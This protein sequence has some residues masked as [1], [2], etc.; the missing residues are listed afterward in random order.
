MLLTGTYHRSVDEKQ[1]L[2]IPKKLRE[3]M[4]PGKNSLLFVAPGTDDSV[5]I[6][7]EEAFEQLAGR[8]AGASPAAEDPRAFHR[9]FFARA[10]QI[11]VD[12]AG[13]I[14]VPAVLAE[15][16]KISKQVVLLGVRDHLELWDKARW[17]AYLSANSPRYD[18]LAAKSF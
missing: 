6:Y 15:L 7:S 8:M 18:D 16:A 9:L 17:D 11:E 14:R 5:A 2:A 4:C 1:R 3:A 13:R 10:E 12:G